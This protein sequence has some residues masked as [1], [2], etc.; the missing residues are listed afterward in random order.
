[1]WKAK[2]RLE[3]SLVALVGG[4]IVCMIWTIGYNILYP[5]V[6]VGIQYEQGEDG[7]NGYIKWVTFDVPSGALKKAMNADITS[8]REE[9]DITLDW[10]DTLSYLAARYYGHWER[11]KAKDMDAYF[12]ARREGETVEA[13]T[14]DL[15]YYPFYRE[16]YAAILGKF[17]G[18]Y[19][20][21]R[22]DPDTPGR[23][24]TEVEY[25][26]CA[27]HPIARGYDYSHYDDFGDG[28][29]YGYRRSHTGND[30]MGAIGTPVVAVESG[31]IE[32][33]GWNQYG[34]WRI[35]IRSFDG[36]RYYYYAHLRKDHPFVLT[37]QEGDSVRAGDV[38][39]YLGMTG[40]STKE[41][42]NNMTVPHL[43][44]GLQLIFD[45]SQHEGT[46]Q[47]WVDVYD[48]IEVLRDR[49][50]TV[51][52]EEESGDFIR[53]NLLCRLD[54]EDY[55]DRVGPRRPVG[56]TSGFWGDAV[57]Q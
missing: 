19:E 56:E 49:R 27:F 43:H 55:F 1:M 18:E 12:E 25:G 54:E 5:P 57:I 16:A 39:G 24:I 38:V 20:L 6:P 47:I 29:S 26:L 42:V 23:W 34:G 28:R 7:E 14:K 32:V 10:V 33:M 21:I 48:L 52:R 9:E 51:Y 40:Y 31:I 41:G 30:L 35:G 13:M 50:C 22:E 4:L 37:L 8:H 11:Y 17:L 46:N 15:D 3:R 2:K 45:E 36:M 53:K 44:F